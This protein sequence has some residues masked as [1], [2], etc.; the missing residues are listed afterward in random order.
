L[1]DE[2]NRYEDALRNLQHEL[3]DLERERDG[4]MKENSKY[5]QDLDDLQKEKSRL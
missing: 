5:A 1:E 4:L 2:K 3:E